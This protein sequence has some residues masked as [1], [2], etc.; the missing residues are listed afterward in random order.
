VRICDIA[1]DGAS[2]LISRALLNLTHRHSREEPTPMVPGA[3]ERVTLTLDALGCAIPAGHRLRVAISPTYWPYVWPSPEPVTLSVFTGPESQLTLPV[4]PPR[5]SDEHAFLEFDP[6]ETAPP[7][8]VEVLREGNSSRTVT[9]ELA[10]GE[11]VETLL[12]DDGR[13]RQRA[14]GLEYESV[15]T[16][17]FR[18]KDDDPL[19][20]TIRCER[21]FAIGRGDW[22]TRVEVWSEQR[23]D[24]EKFY[25]ESSCEAFVGSERIF[26]RTW[27]FDVARDFI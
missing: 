8:A 13:W 7:L 23:S 27:T 10:T 12:A 25:V 19:S 4:R 26:S 2:T 9:R 24:L 1:P 14:N 5:D 21:F 16:T 6:P 20:A 17:R 3:R 22:Q 11:V 18:I 15:T